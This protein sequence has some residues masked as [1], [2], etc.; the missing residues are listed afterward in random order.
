MTYHICLQ[1][2]VEDIL[3]RE[4]IEN[5]TACERPDGT[6]PVVSL[7]IHFQTGANYNHATTSLAKA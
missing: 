5:L 3:F 4:T 7:V 1:G 2:Y 6:V